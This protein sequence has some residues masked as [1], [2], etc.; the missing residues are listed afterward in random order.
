M[1]VFDLRLDL[2]IPEVF[3]NL[4]DYI[5]LCDSVIVLIWFCSTKALEWRARNSKYQILEKCKAQ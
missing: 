3:C 5:F 4:I 1:V 2:M